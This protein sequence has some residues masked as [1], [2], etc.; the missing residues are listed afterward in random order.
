MD[1]E[2]KLLK[3]RQESKTKTE[4]VKPSTNFRDYFKIDHLFNAKETKDEVTQKKPLEKVNPNL[5]KRKMSNIITYDEDNDADDVQHKNPQEF[6]IYLTKLM[7]KILL[8]I[9]LFA[10]FIK[11]E[12]G[13]VY[14]VISLIVIICLNTSNRKKKG[15]LSAYSVFNPN[16]E[17]IQGTLT[18]E[19]IEKS[20]IGGL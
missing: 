13:V 18:P 15:K 5:K 3:F 8:W 12:F 6:K 20:L 4:Y 11:L 2:N 17:R 19:Q 9:I 1:I 16:V 7:L 10:I 14:F